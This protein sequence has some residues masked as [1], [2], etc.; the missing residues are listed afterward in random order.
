MEGDRNSEHILLYVEDGGPLKNKGS[1]P[2]NTGF[3]LIS[4]IFREHLPNS[5]HSSKL[6]GGICHLHVSPHINTLA[7]CLSL[8]SGEAALH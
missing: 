1:F 3:I 6:I 2:V 8:L 5:T 7:D 4:I